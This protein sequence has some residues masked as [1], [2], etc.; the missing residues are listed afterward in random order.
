MAVERTIQGYVFPVCGCRRFSV[1]NTV[2]FSWAL[3]MNSTPSSSVKRARYAAATSSLRCPRSKV[4]SGT[5]CALAK[6]SIAA[7]NAR[8]IG[9]INAEEA[10]TAPR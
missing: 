8:L 10:K 4:N 6:R 7:T 2:A 3:P 5:S 1:R 9:S